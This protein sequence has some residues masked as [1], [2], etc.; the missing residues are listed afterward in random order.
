MCAPY[1]PM[2]AADL[3]V[4][5]KVCRLSDSEFRLLILCW[6]RC[7]L[8]G[9]IP[10]DPS[11]L[12]KILNCHGNRASILGRFLPD[13]FISDPENP[14][15][16]ISKRMSTSLDKY[17]AIVERNHTNGAK[18]GRPKKPSG[19]I[20]GNPEK[21]QPEPEPEPEEDK[22]QPPTP[23][24]GE[25]PLKVE[26]PKAK[27]PAK[28][29]GRDFGIG[30]LDLPDETL[31]PFTRLWNG[32]PRKGWNFSTKTESPRRINRELALQRFSEIL[33]YNHV[34]KADG[35]KLTGEDLANA[36]L[37]WVGKRSKEAHGA[38]PNVP[39]I[40]NLLSSVQGEKN[41]WKEA[42]LEFFGVFEGVG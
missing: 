6:C 12:A 14:A 2:Y 33:K 25:L 11:E 38:P 22:L 29:K 4:D 7:C 36:C 18:G 27:K 23:L 15:R 28:P 34:N 39:C 35:S 19:L 16:L 30:S 3:L 40:A 8:D 41:Q 9:S 1:F 21:S 13:F 26:T 24:Q 32:Y 31:N 10:A 17:S 42:V 37:A 5:A 20:L